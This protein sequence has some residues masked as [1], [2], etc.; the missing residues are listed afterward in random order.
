MTTTLLHISDPHFGDPKG[1]LSRQEVRQVL[2]DL[3]H[4]AGPDV[5]VVLSGDISFKGQAQGYAEARDALFQVFDEAKVLRDRVILCPG[6][7][8]VVKDATSI[9]PFETFDAWSASLRRD[10]RCAFSTDSCRRLTFP[11]V[12]FLLINSAYHGDIEFGLVD[13]TK[14][15]AVLADMDAT[16]IHDL[17]RVAVLHHHLIPFSREDTSTTRN[18]YNVLTRLAKRG[19]SL[20]LHGHQ[21]A[22]LELGMGVGSM[23]VHGV[24]SFRYITPG[25][26]NGATVYRI[27]GSKRVTSEHYAISKDAPNL[28]RSIKNC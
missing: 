12:D 26:V 1:V 10:K 9:S 28:L 11:G 21:H 7:H 19:F 6:N 15:E 13:L 16:P 3:L 4:K 8:D 2:L 27:D 18:A 24:G 17:P 25:F 22:L 5:F 14:M 23:K 20:V